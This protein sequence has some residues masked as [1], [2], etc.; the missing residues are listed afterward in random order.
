[1]E[2]VYLSPHLDDATWS[3]GG[4]IWEQVQAGINLEIWNIFAGYPPPGELSIFA[5]VHHKVWGLTAEEVVDSRRREDADAM[6]ILGAKNRYFDFPD[7]IYRKHPK[8]S[9]ALYVSHEDLFGGLD[10]GDDAIVRQLSSLLVDALPKDCVLVAPLTVGNHVDHQLVR[11]VAEILPNQVIYY[12]EFPYSREF[13]QIIPDLVPASHHV[14]ELAI[15]QRAL[16]VWLH[17]AEC[18][19]SQLSTFW[20]S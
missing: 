4:L 15:S 16:K 3:C 17:S 1:M 10:A 5:Q 8:T 6:K 11:S 14:V 19:A 12:P 13:S 2:F 9:E 7:A 18:Y 20:T